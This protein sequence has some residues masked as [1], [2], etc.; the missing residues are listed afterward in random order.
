[1]N[2]PVA[3]TRSNSNRNLAKLWLNIRMPLVAV[4]VLGTALG[5]GNVVWTDFQEAERV[6][7]LK[8]TTGKSRSFI[9]PLAIR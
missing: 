6:S 9:W 8:R 7:V 4:V 1:M 5:G 2:A 3:P